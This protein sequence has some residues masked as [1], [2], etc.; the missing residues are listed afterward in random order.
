MLITRAFSIGAEREETRA[1]VPPVGVRLW[2]RPPEP[3]TALGPT[4]LTTD[5]RR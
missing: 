3:A 1:I 2:T 4:G 5:R